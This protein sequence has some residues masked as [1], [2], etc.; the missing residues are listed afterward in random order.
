[1]CGRYTLSTPGDEIAE[2]F[3]LAERV[4]LTPRFN[5]APSQE[6][7]VVRRAAEGH[8]TLTGC[9]WGFVPYW[10]ESPDSGP[11]SINARSETVAEKPAFRDSFRRRRC[12]VVGDGFYEWKRANGRKQPF[13]FAL[14]SAAPFAMAGLWDRW[15]DGQRTERTFAILTARAN[16]EVAGVHDRMPMILPATAW[17]AWLDC[18]SESTDA[19]RAL[20]ERPPPDGLL[21]HHAV[22]MRVNSPANDDSS[23]V[24]RV[25]PADED[26]SAPRLF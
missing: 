7:P 25:E 1:M 5:I 11:R 15:S 10:A 19:A 4:E 22:S 6:A 23:L 20:L 3:G 8:R 12:L 26:A 16:A 17:E 13:Y 14:P 2:V 21:A 24:V 9:R 18:S